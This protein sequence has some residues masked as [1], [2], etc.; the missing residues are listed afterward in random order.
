MSR[1]DPVD[2]HFLACTLLKQAGFV[3]SHVS[4]CSESVYMRHPGASE[5]KY[6]RVSHHKN[7][8]PIGVG[9]VAAKITISPRATFYEHSIRGLVE[10]AIGRYFLG[11]PKKSVYHGPKHEKV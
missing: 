9:G 3:T 5:T 10:M 4:A 11:S 6:L 7:K 1:L 2:A 8:A